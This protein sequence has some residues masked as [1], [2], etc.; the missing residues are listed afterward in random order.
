MPLYLSLSLLNAEKNSPV[1]YL[2]TS[3]EDTVEQVMGELTE[4]EDHRNNSL[5]ANHDKTQ[6]TAFELRTERQ[7]DH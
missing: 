2:L 3:V 6:V 5:C 4:T 1:P 7:I